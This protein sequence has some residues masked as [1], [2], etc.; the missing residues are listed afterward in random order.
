MT[1]HSHGWSAAL[2][3]HETVKALT[4]ALPGWLTEG[5]GE[6]DTAAA[7]TMAASLAREGLALIRLPGPD[8]P[9]AAEAE[10]SWFGQQAD[11]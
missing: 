5:D 10:R 9:L 3:H 7:E 1:T 8:S 11:Q 6:V 2:D 4:A